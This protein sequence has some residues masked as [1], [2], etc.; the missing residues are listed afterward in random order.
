[1]SIVQTFMYDDEGNFSIHIVDMDNKVFWLSH[2]DEYQKYGYR[3]FCQPWTVFIFPV[4]LI[5]LIFFNG[6]PTWT[7]G[8]KEIR[9]PRFTS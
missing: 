9:N 5:G 2:E 4:A 3:S 6:R 8:F 1:M 7:W